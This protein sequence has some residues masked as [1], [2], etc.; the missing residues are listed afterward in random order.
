MPVNPTYPGV[1]VQEVPSGVRTIAGVS[2]SIAL[3]IGMTK[4]GPL[5][6]PIR[7][8]N[9]TEFVRNFSDDAS[10]GDLPRAVKLFF[11]NGGTDCYVMRIAQGVGY[12]SVTLRSEDEKPTLDLT[13]KSPGSEGEWIRTSVTYSG[14]QPE[15]TFNITIFSWVFDAAGNK[16]AQASETFSSLSMNPNSSRYAPTFITQNSKLVDAALSAATDAPNPINGYS[17][18]GRPVPYDLDVASTFI[19]AWDALIGSNGLGKKFQISVDGNAYVTVDLSAIDVSAMDAAT[20]QATDLPAAIKAAVESAYTAAGIAGVVVAVSFEE[21]PDPPSAIDPL[22]TTAVLQIRSENEGDVLIKAASSDD[23]ALLL[24][25]GTENGGIEVS[26]Y[27]PL[28]PAP[29]G[30]VFKANDLA[31]WNALGS[32]EQQTIQNI[33][34]DEVDATTGAPT[35]NTFGITGLQTTLA[36]DPF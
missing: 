34:I 5:N 1:Y 29:N 21:G 30:V 33:M 10:I 6:Q 25:L 24:M 8:P 9:Y 4:K 20:A 3:F 18:S 17:I 7:C 35:V 32:L 16:S 13:A 11:T 12:S 19:S 36:E 28:R 14:L 2:T 22:D 23:A 27:S 31:N 15:S 26:A